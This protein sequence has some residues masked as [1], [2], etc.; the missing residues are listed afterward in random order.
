MG[1][2]AWIIVGLIAGWLAKMISPGP[3]R[4]GLL[5][6]LVIGVVGAIVGGWIFNLLGYSGASGVN[7]YSLIV[8]TLGAIVFA[9]TGGGGVAWAGPAQSKLRGSSSPAPRLAGA[10]PSWRSGGRRRPSS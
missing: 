9:S 10:S 4:G 5:V 2:L 1:W 6:T 3:E 8:A 7:L